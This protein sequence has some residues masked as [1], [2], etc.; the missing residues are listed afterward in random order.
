MR[1]RSLFLAAGACLA[2]ASLTVGTAVADPSG[3][4]TFRPL[5]GVGAQ[6]TQGIMNTLSN[7]ITDGS[8]TKI[9][10]SYDNAGSPT[11]T[12]KDP[13]TNPNCTIPRPNQ[14]GAG[15][16][17][18]VNSL[19]AGDGCVQFARAVTNDSASRA[20]AGLT[21]VPFAVDALTYAIRSDSSIPRDLTVAELQA[22]Y[23][24]QVSNIL[25]LLGVFGAG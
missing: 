14:G 20:G 12:T 13:A 24:C 6:T 22:V 10:A 15:T 11:I 7:L 4:P 5:A 8:G 3:P 2:A 16:N 21:Y 23:N 25:P 9:I 1:R 18:L 17:A 19:Q